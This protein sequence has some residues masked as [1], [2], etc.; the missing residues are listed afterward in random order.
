MSAADLSTNSPTF[1]PV[2]LRQI[3]GR[4][5]VLCSGCPPLL[6]ADNAPSNT[7][8]TITRALDQGMPLSYRPVPG[9]ERQIARVETKLSSELPPELLARAPKLQR[10]WTP[11]VWQS[12]IPADMSKY[13]RDEVLWIT[14]FATNGFTRITFAKKHSPHYLPDN[15]PEHTRI[16]VAIRKSIAEGK[17]V[18]VACFSHFVVDVRE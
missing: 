9:N 12:R 13:D 16:M 8:E 11:A 14:H 3:E 7:I 17:P 15:H 10:A 4:W 18:A 2:S 5:Q 6:V 1:L